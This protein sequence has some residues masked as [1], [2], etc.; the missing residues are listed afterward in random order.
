MAG[1]ARLAAI[2]GEARTLDVVFTARMVGAEEA[3]ACGLATEVVAEDEIEAHVLGL[4]E[5]LATHAPITMRVTKEALRRLREANRPRRRR[6]RRG[7]LRQRRLP[8]RASRRSSRSA[9]TPGRARSA[10]RVGRAAARRRS[11][12]G[13]RRARRRPLAADR[14]DRP[15][16]VREARRREAHDGGLAV[17]G[18]VAVDGAEAG[19]ADDAERPQR[20]VPGQR[21]VSAAPAL[22]APRWMSTVW[23]TRTYPAGIGLPRRTACDA[24]GVERGGLPGA[25]ASGRR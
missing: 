9:A 15:R 2:L 11:T 7:G 13:G 20:L 21:N 19:V 8:R 18:V 1:Y 25:R 17:A 22:F 24:G 14:V 6:P 3:R 16:R 5:R 23:P 4:A 10:E 12:S